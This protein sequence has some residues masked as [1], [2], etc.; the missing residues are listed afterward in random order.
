MSAPPTSP[1]RSQA[2]PPA[3][4][5]GRAAAGSL[6]FEASGLSRR[7][8]LL[9]A[10]YDTQRDAAR[11]LGC[12]P[13]TLQNWVAGRTAPGFEAI[14]RL[15][16]E[17]GVSLEWLATGLGD[18]STGSHSLL[19]TYSELPEDV[20]KRLDQ[21][22]QLVAHAHQQREADIESILRLTLGASA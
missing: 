8:G 20:R 9:L 10:R 6:Q 3:A 15:A 5:R 14:T 11:F 13:E 16:L 1:R 4:V 12:A 22:I 21:A 18:M 7:I 2:A 19:S 17:K